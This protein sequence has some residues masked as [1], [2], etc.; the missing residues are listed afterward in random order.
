MNGTRAIPAIEGSSRYA[1][2]YGNLVDYDI[3]VERLVSDGKVSDLVDNK[4]HF[5]STTIY[6][7]F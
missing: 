3:I 6:F 2:A 1:Q 7:R 5:C 4:H